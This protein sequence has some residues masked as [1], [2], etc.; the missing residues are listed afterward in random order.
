MVEFGPNLI[1]FGPSSDES[2]P[3]LEFA[4]S[5]DELQPQLVDF[6]PPSV[7]LGRIRPNTVRHRPTVDRF[8]AKFVAFGPNWSVLLAVAR[9]WAQFAR[10]QPASTGL[11]QLLAELSPDSAI[12]GQLWADHRLAFQDFA[13]TSFRTGHLSNVVKVYRHIRYGAL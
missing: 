13:S 3:T 5:S 4:P 10:S 8:W 2:G 6:R 11:G 9:L 12:I 7:E 1:S